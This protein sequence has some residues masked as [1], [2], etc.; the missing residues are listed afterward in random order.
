MVT[1]IKLRESYWSFEELADRST[2]RVPTTTEFVTLFIPSTTPRT[3]KST[4]MEEATRDLKK[5][6]YIQESQTS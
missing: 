3:S 6:L 1:M 5:K 2:Y 4:Y